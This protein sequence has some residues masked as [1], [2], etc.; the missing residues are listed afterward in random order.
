MAFFPALSGSPDRGPGTKVLMLTYNFRSLSKCTIKRNS[1]SDP[2]EMSNYQ[3]LAIWSK[4]LEIIEFPE[5]ER[6]QD[7]LGEKK[8][9]N[10]KLSV[11]NKFDV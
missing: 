10:K 5:N 7:F 2:L 8:L 9:N 3:I 11:S 4:R 1:E 6:K